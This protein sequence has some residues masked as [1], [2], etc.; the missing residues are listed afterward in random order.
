MISS[1]IVAGFLAGE[2]DA[3]MS[4]SHSISWKEMQYLFP[5]LDFDWIKG[6]L[7]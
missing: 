3:S 2:T 6:G 4:C 1:L 7:V 5:K